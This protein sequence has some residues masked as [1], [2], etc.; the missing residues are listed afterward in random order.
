[1]TQMNERDKSIRYGIPLS[2]NRR[3]DEERNE[4]R[5][6]RARR[7]ERRE[8]LIRE[9][10]EARRAAEGECERLRAEFEA[11]RVLAAQ[12]RVAELEAIAEH[13][14]EA[15]DRLGDQFEARIMTFRNQIMDSA[16]AR[17]ASLERQ[18]NEIEGR[19]RSGFEFARE[20]ADAS[21]VVDLPNPL[22]FKK[23]LDS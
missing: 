10:R 8:E 9:E 16:A 17:F 12:R 11:E 5:L 20:R 3:R 15:L 2:M 19:P 4:E 1:M 22:H 13:V 14:D 18:I 23:R 6:A 7:E 21:K